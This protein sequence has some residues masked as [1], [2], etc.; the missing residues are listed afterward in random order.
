MK[1]FRNNIFQY[2]AAVC[3]IL[4]IAALVS[5]FALKIIAN[6]RTTGDLE[7]ENTVAESIQVNVLNACGEK[8]LAGKTRKY[9]RNNGFDV[10]E[11]GNYNLELEK[12]IIIDRLGD[13]RSAL[14]TAYALGIEDSLVYSNIDSSLFIRATVI[15]GKDFK[16]LKS[17]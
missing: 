4:V 7:L 16:M 1:I 8:G 14:K 15:I 12:S 2:T 11:I 3:G 9:L 17:I 6:N 10:V 13:K 5:S